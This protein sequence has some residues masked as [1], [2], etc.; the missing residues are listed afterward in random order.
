MQVADGARVRVTERDDRSPLTLPHPLE[1][2]HAKKSDDGNDDD[3]G[4]RVGGWI[5]F[6]RGRKDDGRSGGRICGKKGIVGTIC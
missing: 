5:K 1:E 2:P 4:G 3:G 6:H